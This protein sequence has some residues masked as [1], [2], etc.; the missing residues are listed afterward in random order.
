[1]TGFMVKTVEVP[2]FV[3]DLKPRAATKLMDS[4][5]VMLDLLVPRVMTLVHLED[6][7]PTATPTA[8]V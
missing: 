3:S 2:V 6:M 4:A 7:E 5:I 8:L 1:M